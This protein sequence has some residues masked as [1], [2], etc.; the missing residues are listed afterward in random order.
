[1]NKKIILCL[2]I[3]VSL[4]AI[5]HVSAGDNSDYL[6]VD[7]SSD[8]ETQIDENL[9]SE[10]TL[11]IDQNDDE[12]ADGGRDDAIDYRN[13]QSLIN[14]AKEGGT[15]YLNGTYVCDYLIN[16]N[17]T[18][19]IEGQPDA[20]IKLSDEY[21]VHDTPFF[22]VNASNVELKNIKFA[23]GLFLFGGAITWNGDNGRI[24]NCEFSDNI[25]YSDNY[26]IGGA[27]LLLGDHCVL[28]NCIFENNHA[29]QH[30]GA[31]LWY[32]DNGII[33]D[34]QFRGNKATGN[35]GWGGALMLYADNCVVN[36]CIFVNNS[37]TDYGGAI[38]THN[39]TN[40]IVNCHFEDNFVINNVTYKED[41][42]DVQGGAA[43]FSTCIGLSIDGCNFTNNYATNALGGALSLSI[44]N[45]V[46]RSYFRGNKALL[47]N[48]ILA[49]PTSRITL[50]H[51]VL[52]FNE[53]KAQ[54]VY[55]I[56]AEELANSFNTFQITKIN[57]S[58]TFSAGM[59]FYYAQSGEIGV[60]V[61]G[62]TLERENIKVLDHPEAVIEFNDTVLKVSN[63]PVG[64]FTLV[65]TTTPDAN[66]NAVDATLNI[67]V[68]KSQATISATKTKVALKKSTYWSIKVIDAKTGNPISG[69]EL[70]LKV[71]TGKKYKTVTVKTNSS[72]VA[73]YQTK[74][75]AQ[76]SHKI[77]VSGTG[78]GYSFNTVT[79]TIT[80]IKPTPLTFKVK[81]T[82]S[83]DGATLSITVNNKAT[84][85]PVNGIKVTLVIYTGKETQIVE[86]KSKTKAKIKG[87]C[88]FGTNTLTVGTHKV[89][90]MPSDIK[91]S[92]SA[93]S[94]M[95]IKKSAKKYP[96]W[97][98]KT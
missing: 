16:I 20:V 73:K 22:S 26:G 48:D 92:G 74:S 66:H 34:C 37:C 89:V 40:K 61:E 54:A 91:Y 71:Y 29:Y 77:V 6:A 98:H 53:T 44:N 95:V 13:I 14:H 41:G 36:N 82:T 86:L 64:E 87:V 38:A 23:G 25:A 49:S 70:K 15:I 8:I 94:S 57:S 50:N 24:S 2:L 63:L 59:V 1:M 60:I 28:E 9:N 96:A 27:L 76:G 67:T 69:M 5:S 19:H 90:I 31:V 45:T 51:I 7:D 81:K 18:V 52:D 80:V 17:K 47:G 75:L 85:K 65:A 4:C 78:T 42:M 55:G 12:I 30:G 58:V 62:G 79:S 84:K 72:G 11:E 32:G 10:D 33:R 21:Q 83:K 46:S 88:G 97:S 56:S 3:L 68:Q 43:I 39:N 93:T 35:K